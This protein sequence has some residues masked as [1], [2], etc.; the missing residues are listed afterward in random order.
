MSKINSQ[1]KSCIDIFN[2][3]L[4]KIFSSSIRIQFDS[5]YPTSC[6]EVL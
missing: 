2:S 4:V 3:F 1:R 6:K 5:T